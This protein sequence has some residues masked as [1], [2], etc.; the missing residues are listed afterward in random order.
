MS[1]KNPGMKTRTLMAHAIQA[2]RAA[3][4]LGFAPPINPDHSATRA[5]DIKF[6]VANGYRV[7]GGLKIMSVIARATDCYD[8]AAVYARASHYGLS[9]TAWQDYCDDNQL[10]PA[11]A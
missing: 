1:I 9:M 7:D 3:M 10:N 4:R 11:T 2:F 5:P 8:A 6:R